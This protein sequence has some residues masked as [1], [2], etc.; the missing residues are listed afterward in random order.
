MAAQGATLAQG[1]RRRV[2]RWQVLNGNSRPRVVGQL[3]L[4][5]AFGAPPVLPER[6]FR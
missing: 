3:Q 2:G 1:G 6:C 5:T 4:S